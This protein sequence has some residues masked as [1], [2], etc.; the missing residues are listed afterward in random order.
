[1]RKTYFIEGGTRMDEFQSKK[2]LNLEMMLSKADKIEGEIHPQALAVPF[3]ALPAVLYVA[4]LTIG[5]VELGIAVSAGL[6]IQKVQYV[7]Q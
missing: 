7:K 5:A 3:V 1:M 2:D 6:Y 4:V